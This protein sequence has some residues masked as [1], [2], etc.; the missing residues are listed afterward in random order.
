M[1]CTRGMMAG[2]TAM[3]LLVFHTTANVTVRLLSNDFLDLCYLKIEWRTIC[4]HNCLPDIDSRQSEW[5]LK[6]KFS[7]SWLQM[8]AF[9]WMRYNRVKHYWNRTVILGNNNK[10]CFCLRQLKQISNKQP[11]HLVAVDRLSGNT[12]AC[13]CVIMYHQKFA[14]C[15]GK[16]NFNQNLALQCDVIIVT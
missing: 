2:H 13:S 10:V 3:S 14:T 1:L 4:Q 12:P 11:L 6:E 7:F 5:P 8:K 16:W 15:I 9:D